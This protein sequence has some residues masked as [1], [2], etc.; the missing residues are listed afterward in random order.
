MDP[1]PA[2]R[3]LADGDRVVVTGR[4]D[5]VRP[6]LDSAAVAVAPLRVARGL[7]NKVLE[8]MA[9]RVPVVASPAAFNGVHAVADRDLLVAADADAF[10]RCVLSLLGDAATRERYA[11]AGRACVEQNHNWDRLLPE[12]EQLVVGEARNATPHEGQGHVTKAS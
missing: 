12:M 10:G 2:V 11:A 9:M 4:V 1:V 7:Q 6:F 8:A 3:R 5:D